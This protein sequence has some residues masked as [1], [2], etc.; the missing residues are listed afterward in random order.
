LDDG[1]VVN[2][3]PV[4]AWFRNRT[5][6]EAAE[7]VWAELQRGEH[8]WS[9]LALWLR[10]DEVLA[11]CRTERDLA[12]AHGREDMYSPPVN[13]SGRR[14]RWRRRSTQFALPTSEER[15]DG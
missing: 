15:D 3:A 2:A 6:R 11:R 13:N 4:A 10:P 5:W 1:A 7:R 12:I 14:S 9:R 8:D